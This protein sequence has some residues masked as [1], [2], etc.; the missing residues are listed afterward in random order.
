MFR[1]TTTTTQGDLFSSS[2]MLMMNKREQ[3]QFDDPLAW[4][5]AFY[6]NVTSLI[7]EDL[8]SVMY[9]DSGLGAPTA[10]I[11]R[12]VAMCWLKEGLCLSDERLFEACGY[13]LLVRRALGLEDLMESYPSPDTY[14]LFRRRLVEWNESHGEDLLAKC[15]TDVTRKQIKAFR[16]KGSHIRM[17]SKL[18]CSNIAPYG[19]YRIVHST[20]CKEVNADDLE[21]LQQASAVLYRQAK[22][23]LGEDAE[24]VIY[25]SDSPTIRKRMIDLGCLIQEI[26]QRREEGTG[27]LLARVFDEQYV[28]KDKQLELR[29]GKQVSPASVQN[30]NDPDAHY[31]KKGDQQ[32]RGNVVNIT[33]T[34]DE[35][36]GLNLIT[37]VQV[38]PATTADNSFVAEAVSDTE[39]LTGNKVERIYADG[40]YN[41]ETNR[42]LGAELILTGIQGKQGRYRLSK[43]DNCLILTDTQTG[44]QIHAEWIDK[45]KK[46]RIKTEKGYRYFSEEDIQKQEARIKQE[47]TPPDLLKKRNNVEATIRHFACCL[48]KNKSRYRGLLKHKFMAWARCSWINFVR[49]MNFELRMAAKVA[50]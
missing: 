40:A 25:T 26:L 38:A 35:E 50:Y 3:R 6:K 23:I 14:Y 42:Q 24:K 15:Y 21:H 10:S 12:L 7:D 39:Q 13:N 19:R 29:E 28:V 43:Q 30:P 16:L 27:G 4:H 20:F 1:K 8:F 48:E 44:E 9:K 37:S 45:A 34:V 18:V 31:R 49:I 2:S 36:N 32:V 17:D 33:E 47:M 46:W 11:R 5:N 41:S 22:D